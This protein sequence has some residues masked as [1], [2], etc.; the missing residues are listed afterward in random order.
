MFLWNTGTDSPLT[1]RHIPEENK[2]QIGICYQL[3]YQD[4]EKIYGSPWFIL[5]LNTD[6]DSIWTTAPKWYKTLRRVY[7]F[8]VWSRMK[9][10]FK[11]RLIHVQLHNS[12]TT[13]SAQRL[14]NWTRL[15]RTPFDIHSQWMCCIMCWHSFSANRKLHFS[16]L[17]R[18]EIRQCWTHRAESS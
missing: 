5:W 18:V 15:R 3:T 17:S 13:S 8:K 7:D 16:W 1:R 6:G 14:Q 9:H 12:N 4:P 2:P 10:F 11:F